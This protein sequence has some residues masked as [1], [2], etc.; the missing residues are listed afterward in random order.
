MGR[1]AEAKGAGGALGLALGL[2]VL[3]ARG[4]KRAEACRI[5]RLTSGDFE[6]VPLIWTLLV[7]A[8]PFCARSAQ[9]F[10]P[11]V[12]PYLG[13]SEIPLARRWTVFQK[14]FSWRE[15]RAEE[16]PVRT[17]KWRTFLSDCVGAQEL[18]PWDDRHAAALN[19]AHCND[20]PKPLGQ[21]WEER[22]MSV[23]EVPRGERYTYIRDMLWAGEEDLWPRLWTH[24]PEEANVWG[25]RMLEA[26]GGTRPSSA[27]RRPCKKKLS[28]RRK[29]TE[30]LSTSGSA[31][32]L[33]DRIQ[34]I[35]IRETH[36]PETASKPEGRGLKAAADFTPLTRE[37]P[38]PIHGFSRE[39]T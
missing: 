30:R 13:S 25:L 21:V 2:Y 22:A 18:L 14:A 34:E 23:E 9:T 29:D 1:L 8:E 15:L 7:E 26:R 10:K 32:P 6:E 20:Q 28:H 4:D 27:S 19:L 37:Q 33:P 36:I 35:Q 16:P 11:A 3:A 38:C 31:P 24:W 39:N 5:D 12:D 17:S